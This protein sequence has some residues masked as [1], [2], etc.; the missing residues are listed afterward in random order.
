MSTVIKKILGITINFLNFVQSWHFDISAEMGETKNFIFRS[1][2][3]GPNIIRRQYFC[4][5]YLPKLRWLHANFLG[6]FWGAKNLDNYIISWE[7]Q[8]NVFLHGHASC[9]LICLFAVHLSICITLLW[10]AN[11]FLLSF[12]VMQYIANIVSLLKFQ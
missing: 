2:K 1:N 11:Y 8:C 10:F 12:L 7:L 4:L 3:D 5:F 6:I 9:T